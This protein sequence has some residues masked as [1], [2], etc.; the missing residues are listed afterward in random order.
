MA[1][2][3]QTPLNWNINDKRDMELYEWLHKQSD[4]VSGFVKDILFQ[5]MERKLEQEHVKRQ[6]EIMIAQKEA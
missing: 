1:K 4:N 5:Y 2:R 3:K 6:Y